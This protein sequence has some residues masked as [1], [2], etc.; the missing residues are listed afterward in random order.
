MNCLVFHKSFK[1]MKP[2]T[3]LV[4]VYVQA[5]TQAVSLHINVTEDSKM[6][7]EENI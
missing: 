6:E 1:K 5:K 3:K 2:L 7:K 4:H